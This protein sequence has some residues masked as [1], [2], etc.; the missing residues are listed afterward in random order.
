M[1]LF[2]GRG[3]IG[4]VPLDSH[5]SHQS[6]LFLFP[7]SGFYSEIIFLIDMNLENVILKNRK[8]KM[9]IEGEVID[10]SFLWIKH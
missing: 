1:A 8:P 10:H 6:H 2:P 7:A 3:G 5:E 4:G 9:F